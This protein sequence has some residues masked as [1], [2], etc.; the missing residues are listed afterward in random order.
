MTLARYLGELEDLPGNENQSA[1][2]SKLKS[3]LKSF[4]GMRAKP[5]MLFDEFERRVRTEEL[6]AWYSSPDPGDLFQGTS[7]TSLVAPV[8]FRRPLQLDGVHRLEEIIACEYIK[9]HDAYAETVRRAIVE[10]VD[11]WIRE[12]LFY[13]VVLPS[14]VI[15]QAF[16]LAADTGD[17]LARIAGKEIDPHEIT[18]YSVD[19]RRRYF[20]D[21]HKR[22]GCFGG[23]RLSRREFESSLALADVS[24]PNM[25]CYKHKALLGPVRCNEI[26]CLMARGIKGLI[27]QKSKGRITPR[28]FEVV[29]YDTDTPY[30]YHYIMGFNGRP[31]APCLPGLT[32]LGASGSCDAFRWLYT[33]R[34]SL[35]AQKVMRGSLYSQ[36]KSSFVPFVFMGVLV[37]R[38]AQILI[39]MERLDLLR[40]PGNIAADTEF[41][42]LAQD[43]MKY[44]GKAR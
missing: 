23:M 34:V 24:K 26:A 38:D 18:S 20:E 27:R 42:W 32:V 25:Q 33:Y 9:A 29:I 43:L 4:A 5:R 10:P 31:E 40:Y 30:T 2:D 7:V 41:A 3:R 44:L 6:K 37:P 35:I 15:S 28:S 21:I 39:D 16:G 1:W 36:V 8:S 12:G 17:L 19:L 13:G 14:K 22:I 11:E